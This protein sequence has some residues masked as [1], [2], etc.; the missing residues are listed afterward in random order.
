MFMEH[1]S[2][3]PRFAYEDILKD[4]PCS[5]NG[6]YKTR[7]AQK[8]RKEEKQKKTFGNGQIELDVR[9]KRPPEDKRRNTALLQETL[10][11]PNSSWN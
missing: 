4:F 2:I 6:F 1:F 9:I 5:K 7:T 8:A 10:K 3:R 11:S